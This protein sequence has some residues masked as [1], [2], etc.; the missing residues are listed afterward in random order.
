AATALRVSRR[1]LQCL[2]ADGRL[3]SVRIG[4]RVLI[5]KDDIR[6]FVHSCTMPRTT[7]TAESFLGKDGCEP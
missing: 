5:R 4:R 7:P 1:F 3:G 2:V 6:E